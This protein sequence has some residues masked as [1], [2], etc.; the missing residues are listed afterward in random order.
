M[1]GAGSS[2]P[3]ARLSHS[4]RKSR[5]RALPRRDLL[6]TVLVEVVSCKSKQTFEVPAR[7]TKESRH[8]VVEPRSRPRPSW[9]TICGRCLLRHRPFTVFCQNPSSLREALRRMR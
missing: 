1:I 3:P 9:R 5:E 7:E 2:N 4:V 8:K 6:S